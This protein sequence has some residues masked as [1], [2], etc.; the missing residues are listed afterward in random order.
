M[1][2]VARDFAYFFGR[3]KINFGYNLRASFL[4]IYESQA[5]LSHK[6]LTNENF[7][8]RL[9]KCDRLVLNFLGP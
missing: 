6:H 8:G 4:S 9:S 7:L 1:Q 3:K 2:N 5:N